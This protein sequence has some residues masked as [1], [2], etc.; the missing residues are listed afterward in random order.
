MYNKSRV[1]SRNVIILLNTYF[2][3]L[4]FAP[5]QEI[6]NEQKTDF[7]F[8]P[9]DSYIKRESLNDEPELNIQ[10]MAEEKEFDGIF[11]GSPAPQSQDWKKLRQLF[12]HAKKQKKLGGVIRFF[13]EKDDVN[14]IEGFNACVRRDELKISDNNALN[15]PEGFFTD[16]TN[17][18]CYAKY[19]PESCTFEWDF[20][21]LL[22]RKPKSI[23][24]AFQHYAHAKYSCHLINP[25]LSGYGA[26]KYIYQEY[27]K[28]RK[29]KVLVHDEKSENI[30]FF[31]T[32][33]ALEFFADSP[34]T[35]KSLNELLKTI[36][37]EKEEVSRKI[38]KQKRYDPLNYPLN[39][40]DIQNLKNYCGENPSYDG[41]T[42][43]TILSELGLESEKE[44]FYEEIKK[45][46]FNGKTFN[47]VNELY[48]LITAYSSVRKYFPE[49]TIE[50]IKGL[51]EKTEA[52]KVS[53]NQQIN[54]NLSD[55]EELQDIIK[56]IGIEEIPEALI[57]LEESERIRSFWKNTLYKEFKEKFANEDSYLEYINGLPITQLCYEVWVYTVP[58]ISKTESALFITYCEITGK[59]NESL[60]QIM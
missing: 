7:E 34:Y 15:I 18:K 22:T 58:N 1:I 37:Q 10:K 36:D 19:N 16:I 56:D 12:S 42:M 5:M 24:R 2:R 17:F 53:L 59:T 48:R 38:K 28:P 21:H 20:A 43:P 30:D 40:K 57:Q 25:K 6:G 4:F 23:Y 29:E 39:K 33:Y 46:R 60:L 50:I 32:R 26:V 8:P 11:P 35:P 41:I 52:E 31:C 45:E 51:Y 3:G 49:K 54:D 44:R 9:I 47:K 14:F 13:I 27:Q 55:H